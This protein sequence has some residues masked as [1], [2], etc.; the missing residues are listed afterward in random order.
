MTPGIKDA[1]S[2]HA[3]LAECDGLL[4]CAGKIAA[5]FNPRTP[6]GV[7]HIKLTGNAYWLKFQS[8]HS[9]RSATN[10]ALF[11]IN[12]KRKFQ[13][14]HSLRSAT[15]FDENNLTL[16][17]KFQST[18]SLRSATY[19]VHHLDGICIVSIHALLAECDASLFL[20][21][22]KS[23][24]FNPRTPCGVRQIRL[25]TI[26]YL[27][28]FQSTHSLRSATKEY[29]YCSFYGDVSIHALLAEC[30]YTEAIHHIFSFCFNPRTPC[31][32]RQFTVH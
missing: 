13:S 10:L 7:R 9:L 32:V 25:E 19:K 27:I 14:T 16:Y 11:F 4:L 26:N 28:R 30:D 20:L 2:I 18:H 29:S 23:Y 5:G 31:G 8:T 3:L 22:S 24:S 6:C 12:C 1:V 17:F 21:F 15:P